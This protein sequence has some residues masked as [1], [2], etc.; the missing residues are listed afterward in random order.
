MDI[1]TIGFEVTDM[2]TWD[3]VGEAVR[4]IEGSLA[5]TPAAPSDAIGNAEAIEFSPWNLHAKDIRIGAHSVELDL[6]VATPKIEAATLQRLSAL[7]SRLD[8]A[9][10]AF[11]DAIA[12]DFK[13]SSFSRDALIPA[14]FHGLDRA[15]LA[16]LFPCCADAAAVTVETFLASLSLARVAYYDSTP[17]RPGKEH[18][19]VDYRFLVPALVPAAH[20]DP[21]DVLTYG[22]RY[23][24]T[25]QAVVVYATL[26]GRVLNVSHES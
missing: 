23:D 9:H 14:F 22:E 4:T 19:V 3:V 18:V 8:E 15:Y 20:Q 24:V 12:H 26:D 13:T 25:N 17:E 5:W 7:L 6:N 16:T 11:Q 2:R 1:S 21:N 10:R